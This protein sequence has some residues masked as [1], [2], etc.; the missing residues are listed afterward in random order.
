MALI[1]LADD[2]D[3]LAVV[4]HDYLVRR[5]HQVTVV[6][7]GAAAAMKAQ[8]IKPNLLILDLH[9]PG[10]YGSTVVR[11]LDESGITRTTPVIFISGLPEDKAKKLALLPVW[12]NGRLLKKPLDMAKL[13]ATIAELLPPKSGK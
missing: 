9:M 1:L 10:A 3:S 4:I 12:A 6:H 11:M 2:D 13:E 7:D 8:E 5:G